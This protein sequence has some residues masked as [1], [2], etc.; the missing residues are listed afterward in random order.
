M[1]G[2]IRIFRSS[3]F[4]ADASGAVLVGVA[5]DDPVERRFEDHRL[6]SLDRCQRLSL[7]RCRIPV[8]VV[9]F[10]LDHR[11]IVGVVLP[12]IA[13]HDEPFDARTARGRE[14]VRRP[15]RPQLVRGREPS[16]EVAKVGPAAQRR[17]LVDDGVRADTGDRLADRDRVKTIEQQ[18][19]RTERLQLFEL[20]AAPRRADDLVAA[21]DEVGDEVDADHTGRARDENSHIK[22][23]FQSR[24]RDEIGKPHVTARDREMAFEFF[25]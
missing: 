8:E 4:D 11:P 17:H 10:G 19:L 18:R 23:P 21:A 9:G 15:A 1:I 22:P 6:H 24:P 3:T 5:Q 12:G 13:L 2:N 7:L 25:G 14:Q 16:I 20:V